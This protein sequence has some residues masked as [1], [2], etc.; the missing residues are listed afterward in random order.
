MK[1]P[2]RFN[3]HTKYKAT[4]A[5][6]RF[7]QTSQRAQNCGCFLESKSIASAT[8]GPHN[9]TTPTEC[10]DENPTAMDTTATGDKQ[11][12]KR[13]HEIKRAQRLIPQEGQASNREPHNLQ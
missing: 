10:K 13:Q 9:A 5:K 1:S 3:R 7:S 2:G 12:R 6:L 11:P 4:N 8:S